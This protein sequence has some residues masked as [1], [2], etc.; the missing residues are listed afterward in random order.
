M[1]TLWLVTG[2]MLGV[3]L[4]W[5]GHQLMLTKFGHSRNYSLAPL[6][7]ASRC[8]GGR[9]A[10]NRRKKAAHKKNKAYRGY[11]LLECIRGV[12]FRAPVVQPLRQ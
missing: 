6:P 1:W 10:T 11:A 4:H 3:G 5:T 8:D 12:R 2:C 7:V 9:L